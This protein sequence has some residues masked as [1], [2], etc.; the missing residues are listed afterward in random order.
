M[1][2]RMETSPYVYTVNF[3]LHEQHLSVLDLK[4]AINR[5]SGSKVKITGRQS[6]I[7]DRDV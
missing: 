6:F 3:D 1:P 2:L 7:A 5:E 4:W